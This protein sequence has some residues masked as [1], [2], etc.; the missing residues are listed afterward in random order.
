LLRELADA[1]KA[2]IV[3]S[4][5]LLELTAIADRIAVMSSGRLVKTFDRGEWTQEKIMDAALSGY[6]SQSPSSTAGAVS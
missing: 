6:T 3:V 2:I 1:G 5:D 4:S